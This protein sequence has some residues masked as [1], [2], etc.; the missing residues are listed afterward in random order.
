MAKNTLKGSHANNL[1]STGN[2][3]GKFSTSIAGYYGKTLSDEM[4]IVAAVSP[5]G[6]LKLGVDG[7][8]RANRMRIRAGV[9]A[10]A[11]D[12]NGDIK[13]VGPSMTLD[14]NSQAGVDTDTGKAYTVEA[15][16]AMR[17]RVSG[18]SDTQIVAVVD[19]AYDLMVDF[20]DHTKRDAL[21][22]ALQAMLLDGI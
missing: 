11:A 2:T 10:D 18:W 13:T 21:D 22:T 5:A 8:D 12:A 4:R 15:I 17:E 6:E 3:I 20:G 19:K 16:V 7:K 9:V 14:L 1:P